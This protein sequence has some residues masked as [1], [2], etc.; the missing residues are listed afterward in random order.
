MVHRIYEQQVDP[1]AELAAEEKAK[2][3]DAGLIT[4]VATVVQKVAAEIA[5]DNAVNGSLARKAE[6]AER[7]KRVLAS[8]KKAILDCASCEEIE[9]LLAQ[10]WL[11]QPGV[12][13]IALDTFSKLALRRL[14]F[15]ET[16]SPGERASAH[17]EAVLAFK[18]RLGETR[19]DWQAVLGME[20]VYFV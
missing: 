17:A 5:A 13:E 4:S 3:K 1:V 20:G 10:G 7:Y 16:L 2:A 9:L 8:Q 19:Q 18:K 15:D 12:L 11:D 14:R 6:L